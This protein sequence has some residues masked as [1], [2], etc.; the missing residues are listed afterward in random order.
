M[1]TENYSKVQAPFGKYH[2]PKLGIVDIRD[3]FLTSEP[4]SLLD[5]VMELGED[6]QYLVFLE[7]RK[8][9]SLDYG[10]AVEYEE[11]WNNPFLSDC[12][13]KSRC[14]SESVTLG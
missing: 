9:L 13:V 12:W 7:K 1:L 8:V 2:K 5:L 10:R 3:G 14:V 11:T 6:I 4:I